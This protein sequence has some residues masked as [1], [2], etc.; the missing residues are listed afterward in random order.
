V[1]SDPGCDV[2]LARERSGPCV[3]PERSVF[4]AGWCATC[5]KSV[6]LTRDGRAR[7]AH[8]P[9]AVQLGRQ[10]L[11]LRAIA[12]GATINLDISHQ[13]MTVV[14]CAADAVRA[15]HCRGAVD[16]VRAWG[17]DNQEGMAGSRKLGELLGEEMLVAEDR[18]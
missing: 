14:L 13:K 5:L 18:S 8:P 15:E 10:R 16:G 1:R 3:G 9:N 11:V 2:T 4:D 17:V 7:R 6:E 12:P